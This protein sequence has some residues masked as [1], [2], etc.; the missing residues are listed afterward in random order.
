MYYCMGILAVTCVH[1]YKQ[2]DCINGW[3]HECFV[4]ADLSINYCFYESLHCFFY[5]FLMFFW[6]IV[7]KCYHCYE[8]K[9][10]ILIRLHEDTLFMNWNLHA[11][12]ATRQKAYLY[13][14]T[15]LIMHDRQSIYHAYYNHLQHRLFCHL[16]S[17]TSMLND[18]Y[19]N[20]RGVTYIL[21]RQVDK[22]PDQMT[23]GITF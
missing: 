9:G 8:M 19:F 3:W 18:R 22:L 7:W 23:V 21:P 11:I 2:T 17:D 16:V 1:H 10:L 6:Y 13:L 4:N 12:E 20:A 14:V 5:L 15:L